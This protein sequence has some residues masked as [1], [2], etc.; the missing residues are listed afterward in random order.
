MSSTKSVGVRIDIDIFDKIKEREPD[1]V[2]TDFVR[3][4]LREYAEIK[5]SSTSALQEK[6]NIP[7]ALRE[8]PKSSPS[9]ITRKKKSIFSKLLG[10]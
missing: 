3:S 1:F 8:Q 9:A 4:A 10:R 5:T 2:L 6:Q 7:S